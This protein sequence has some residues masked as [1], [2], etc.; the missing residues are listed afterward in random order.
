MVICMEE[1]TGRIWMGL[2]Y[3]FLSALL[4]SVALAFGYV[5]M[6]VLI[7]PLFP[8]LLCI[9]PRLELGVGV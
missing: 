6:F 1:Y 3:V 8:T 9:F 7:A 2:E 5:L 4:Q